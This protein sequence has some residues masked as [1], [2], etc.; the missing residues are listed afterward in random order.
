[1]SIAPM[2]GYC[3]CTNRCVPLEKNR[4][5]I[6]F[7]KYNYELVPNEKIEEY[8]TRDKESYKSLL[9]KWFEENLDRI[10]D[11]KWEIEEIHYLKNISDWRYKNDKL[12]HFRTS[13]F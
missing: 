13:V 5:Y 1:M 3:V 7:H 2:R 8:K 12:I 10:V 11:R 9:N 4:M 6:D